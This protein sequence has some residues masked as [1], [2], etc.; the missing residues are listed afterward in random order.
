MELRLVSFCFS[1]S[2]ASLLNFVTSLCQFLMLVD[3]F[4]CFTK[5]WNKKEFTTILSEI[6]EFCGLVVAPVLGGAVGVCG[7]V[8]ALILSDIAE[9]CKQQAYRFQQFHS[10]LV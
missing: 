8:V 2:E 10:T 5:D 4:T 1:S 3:T 7:L 6:A 9:F